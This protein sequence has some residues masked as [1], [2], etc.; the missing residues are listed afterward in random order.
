MTLHQLTNGERN[1]LADFET[2]PPPQAVSRQELADI[3]PMTICLMR[4]EGSMQ[5]GG[6]KRKR[7]P[8]IPD[9]LEHTSSRERFAMPQN[10]A[11]LPIRIGRLEL[12]SPSTSYIPPFKSSRNFMDDFEPEFS[13]NSDLPF[14]PNPDS[15]LSNETSRNELSRA[16]SKGIHLP[17]RASRIRIME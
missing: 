14:L 17:F 15:M 12:E 10:A 2:P 8:M 13:S 16:G 1:A 9:E 6:T 11:R 4:R 3:S 7:L 5:A